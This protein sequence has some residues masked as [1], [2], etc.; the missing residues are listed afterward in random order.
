MKTS[1]AEICV[2]VHKSV[3]SMSVR[4]WEEARRRYYSTPSSYMEL[5]KLYSKMLKDNKKEFMSNR[6]AILQL[7]LLLLGFFVCNKKMFGIDCTTIDNNLTVI[8]DNS[9]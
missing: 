4:F 1:A 8:L 3:A 5:I 2:K 6:Y 7:S 9:V